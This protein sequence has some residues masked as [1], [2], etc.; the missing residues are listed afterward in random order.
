MSGKPF[1]A[2]L[3]DIGIANAIKI[4]RIKEGLSQKDL[5]KILGI[6]F[7]QM[8]KFEVADNRI[9]ASQLYKIAQALEI[10]VG[11][12]YNEA[13][14]A[15]TIHDKNMSDLIMRMYKL[16]DDDR[17]LLRKFIYRLAR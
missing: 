4:L 1:K 2:D 8:Q 17:A 16:S 5:A 13:N 15:A 12:L 11:A 6:S 9:S 3:V 14:R 10:P 7:Q